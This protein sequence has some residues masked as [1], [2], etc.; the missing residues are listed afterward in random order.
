MPRLNKLPSKPHQTRV[1][2][3]HSPRDRELLELAR[4]E[5]EQP[6]SPFRF[7]RS[8]LSGLREPG[9]SITLAQL[10]AVAPLLTRYRSFQMPFK[11]LSTK[12]DA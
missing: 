12:D 4:C 2:L 6:S 3:D 5:A 8:R 7:S 9:N 10:P 1:S 11:I